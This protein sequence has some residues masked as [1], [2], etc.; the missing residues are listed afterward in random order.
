VARSERLG[1]AACPLSRVLKTRLLVVGGDGAAFR[2]AI[3]D[4]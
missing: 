2:M 1:F 4:I 3:R